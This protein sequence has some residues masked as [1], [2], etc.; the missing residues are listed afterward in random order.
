MEAVSKGASAEGGH[1]IGVTAPSLF[2]ERSGPNAY[3]KELIEAD[4]LLSRIGTMIERAGGVIALPGSIG[5]ATELLVA[6]NHNYLTRRNGGK[7]LPTVAVGEG[8]RNMARAFLELGSAEAGDVQLV[9]KPD[10][11]V[12]W[13]LTAI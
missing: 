10:Q 12:D 9:A 11:A 3:V 13:L 8:W 4:G 1:V 5:T 6:W 2:P 7:V